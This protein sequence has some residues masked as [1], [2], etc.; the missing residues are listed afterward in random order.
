[1]TLREGI[2]YFTTEHADFVDWIMR[3]AARM[4]GSPVGPRNLDNVFDCKPVPE[5]IT[6]SMN[7]ITD[8]VR[9]HEI[10]SKTMICDSREAT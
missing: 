5:K 10:N 4:L 8:D 9:E 6:V 2:C 1:M 3:K 7:R